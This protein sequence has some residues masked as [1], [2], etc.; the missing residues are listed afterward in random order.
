MGRRIFWVFRIR[1]GSGKCS[2]DKEALLDQG[3]MQSGLKVVRARRIL[4]VKARIPLS[5]EPSE[6]VRDNE[7]ASLTGPLLEYKEH[8]PIPGNRD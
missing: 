1:Y 4:Q 2:P 8:P 5:T 3:L 7:T 6:G